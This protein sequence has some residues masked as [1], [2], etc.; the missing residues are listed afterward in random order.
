MSSP[1]EQPTKKVRLNSGGS[2]S[3]NDVIINNKASSEG[4]MARE[5]DVGITE[6]ID[7]T[8]PGFSGVIKQR[9][10]DFLVYEIDNSGNIVHLTDFNL[11]EVK[12]TNNFNA[13]AIETL[14]DEL[15]KKELSDEQ[16]FQEMRTL[17]DE[18]TSFQ[19]QNLLNGQNEFV[20]TMVE[21]DKEKRTA[22]HQFFKNYFGNKLNTETKDGT[23]R[24]SM[25]T[26]ETRKDRRAISVQKI[27]AN[28]IK[29]ERLLGINQK[30]RG[31]KLGNFEYVKD[32]LKLGDLG[33]NHFVITLKNIQV[34]NE[35]IIT[36]AMDSL[37]SH[38]FINYFGMQRFGTSSIPTFHIGR[39]LL[40]NNWEE[41]IDLIMKP[42]PGDRQ[43]LQIA[44]QHWIENHDPKKALE[45]FPKKC[46]AETYI[47]NYFTK[48]GQIKDYAGAFAT[49]P[50]NLRL[51][52]VH[53]YQSYV[54]N[55]I[56]SERIRIY[57]CDAPIVGDLV[58]IDEDP[59]ANINDDDL[60]DDSV[61][62]N[63]DDKKEIKV[64]I[65]TE[66]DLKNYSIFDVVLP[67]PGYSV[68]YPNNVIFEKYKELMWKDRLD[69]R[70][71]RR[72]NKD[73]SLSGS[74]RKL[75]GK[76]SDL[77][78]KFFKYDDSNVSLALTDIDLLD[79]KSEPESLTVFAAERAVAI[80]AVLQASKVCQ[81]VFKQLVNSETITK[82][83]KS[84]VTVAD[85]SAQAVVNTILYHSFPNDPIIG[86]EDTKDLRCE[87]GKE[88]RAKILSLTNSVLDDPLDETTLLDAIDRGSYPGGSQ[89]RMWTLDPIDGTKGFLRGEQFAVCLA[90]L[91]DGKVKLGVMGCPN[92]PVDSKVPEGEKGCLFVAE[93]GQG[94]FQ[95]KFSSTEE[96]KIQMANISSVLD[97]SFC[98]SVEAA[99]S[100]HGDAAKI[101]SLLGITKSPIRMD[102]QCKYCSVARGDADIY[103]RLPTRDDYEENIWDHASGFLLVQEAGGIVSDIYSKPLDFSLGRTLKSNKGVVVSYSKISSQVIEAVQKVLLKK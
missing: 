88:L 92:L 62:V 95:R 8:I 15:V 87:S 101:A 36:K 21:K 102:S 18:E 66:E 27:T 23:I 11:P 22:I 42:R 10:S 43:D 96:T 80:N 100:S 1:E 72:S 41:A 34:G 6:F 86:E 85:F 73:F 47:L 71:M 9:F 44:R 31:M 24:I 84:P 56:V 68:V 76:P 97:A 78:W 54:W 82:K 79:G 64:K 12:S 99:H 63:T 93:K 5:V 32:P 98:E 67:L 57:G 38:G 60:I 61:I 58:I 81:K 49:I 83:D 46:I 75:M 74:Y 33:G 65:L 2:I 77:S 25:H 4:K 103:L 30:S 7:P 51:M 91:V 13:R 14:K 55:S 16:I 28:R 19:V 20:D 45:L 37:Q 94:A 40:Q 59:N 39:S 29:A 89:G 90:L 50:R 3:S 48:T 17:L 26:N 35:E 53:A 69:P 70:E 52:Y